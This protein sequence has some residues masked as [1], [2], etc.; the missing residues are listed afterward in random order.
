MKKTFK[1]VVMSFAGGIQRERPE[2]EDT[3]DAWN[4]AND[5]GSKWFFYPFAFV[6]TGSGKTV[7][8]TPELLEWAKS[9]RLSTVQKR[10]AQAAALPE[11]ANMEWEAF[12]FLLLE[13][14]YEEVRK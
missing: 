8:K 4:Y 5:L 12:S 3:A 2:F 1:I 6:V 7:V 13:R 11:A 14:N 9:L 10:F